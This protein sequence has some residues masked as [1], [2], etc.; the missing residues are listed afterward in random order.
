MREARPRASGSIPFFVHVDTNEPYARLRRSSLEARIG[1]TL[2]Q[3]AVAGLGQS[4]SRLASVA[5]VP[6]AMRSRSLVTSGTIGLSHSAR[7]HAPR[8]SP[9]C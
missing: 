9:A 7:S 1:Q 2:D 5:C 8:H 4:V 3:N 6:G